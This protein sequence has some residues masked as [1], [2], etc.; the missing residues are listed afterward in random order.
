MRTQINPRLKYGPDE[1]PLILFAV[2]IS[3]PLYSS[4]SAV[5][6]RR[7]VVGIGGGY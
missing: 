7:Y 3:L 2:F 6:A 5:N 1:A 4:G